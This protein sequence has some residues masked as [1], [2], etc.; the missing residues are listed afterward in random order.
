MY[1]VFFGVGSPAYKVLACVILFCFF[2]PDPPGEDWR[3][4]FLEGTPCC[5]YTLPRCPPHPVSTLSLWFLFSRRPSPPPL[6]L[7]RLFSV[8]AQLTRLEQELQQLRET[9]R[10]SNRSSAARTPAGPSTSSAGDAAATG[11]I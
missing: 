7:F 10:L 8:Q 1:G 6:F 5:W 3:P 9:E 2:F 11:D 4:R